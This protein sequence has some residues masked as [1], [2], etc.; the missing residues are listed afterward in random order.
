MVCMLKRWPESEEIH[1]ESSIRDLPGLSSRSTWRY[2]E[3]FK[4]TFWLASDG[5]LRDAIRRA[6][7]RYDLEH[8][9]SLRLLFRHARGVA[10]E[11]RT[12]STEGVM[13]T[14]S[15]RAT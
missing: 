1:A 4:S 6:A 12:L 2:F 5:E 13:A 7:G 11:S 15:F 10:G 9:F 8:C 3:I 14:F